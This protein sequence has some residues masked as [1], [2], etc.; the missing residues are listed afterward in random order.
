MQYSLKNIGKKQAQKQTQIVNSKRKRTEI[1]IAMPYVKPFDRAEKS[2]NLSKIVTKIIIATVEKVSSSIKLNLSRLN[3]IV[4][5][6]AHF[7][8]FMALGLLTINMLE[9]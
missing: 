5:K 7:I 2:N 8:V 4:R 9:T 6:S 3:C 1:I